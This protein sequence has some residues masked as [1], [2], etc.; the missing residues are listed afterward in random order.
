MGLSI[1]YYFEDYTAKNNVGP[2]QTDSAVVNDVLNSIFQTAAAV[3]LMLTLLL[4]NTIPGSDQE[5]GLHVWRCLVTAT[6]GTTTTHWW[7]DDHM[8]RVRLLH[9]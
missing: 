5:R 3:S 7:E 6:D 4:D 9:A 2:I 1:P 8:N